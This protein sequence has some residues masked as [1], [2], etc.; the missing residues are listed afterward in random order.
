MCSSRSAHGV[1][2]L[3]TSHRTIGVIVALSLLAVPTRI[4]AAQSVP[5]MLETDVRNSIGDAWDVWT[6]PLRASP[7]SWLGAAGAVALS[8]VVSPWDDNIDRWAARHRDDN[9]FSFLKELRE[10]G[11]A[12]SG[13]KIAPVAGGAL[14]LSLIT[15]NERFQEG[16][17]GCLTAYGASSAVRTFVVYPLVA[18]TRP[19]SGHSTIQPPPAKSG[20]QYKFSFPGTSDWGRHA[21]PGGHL[22]NV[23]ACAEFLTRRFSMGSI[24]PAAWALAA[25][26]GL[27]RTLDR[28]HWTSDQLIG[29]ALGYAVGKEIAVRSRRRAALAHG[30]HAGDDSGLFIAPDAAGIKLGWSRAF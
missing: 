28:R 16:L 12:Y 29:V 27:G 20:D 21:L 22:T 18:R 2:R 9:T 26:V 6:S 7:K 23:V 14:V 11:I 19:D 13:Q 3:A 30:E 10:G 24:E 4:V 25:G 5:K 8:A 17:F 1:I 15:K